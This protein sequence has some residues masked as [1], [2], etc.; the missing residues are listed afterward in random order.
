MLDLM[1]GP[2]LGN[3]MHLLSD[4]I[5]GFIWAAPG[6]KLVVSDYSGIEGA[7]IAW[8]AGEQW[9]LEA[10]HEIIANPELPDMYQRTA[11]QIMGVPVETIGRKHHLRQAVGKLAELGLS[12]AGAVGAFSAMARNYQVDLDEL[13][14]PVME[15]SESIDVEAARE[16]YAAALSRKEKTTQALSGNAWIASELIKR[17]WR[18]SNPAIKQFWWD[19]EEGVRLAVREPGT[20]A[21]VGKV[22]Y[23]VAHGYL[24]CRLPSGRCLAYAN[25]RL[26]PQVYASRLIDGAWAEPEVMEADTAE[27][28]ALA[29][30]CRI[31]RKSFPK[32]TVLGVDGKTRQFVRFGLYGGL[33]AEN[34]VQ[35]AA[36]DIL[37]HGMRLAESAGYAV[38]GHVYDEIITEVDRGFGSPEEFSR[39]ICQL[40]GWAAGLPLTAGGYQSKRYRKD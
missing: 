36:R 40:P 27:R 16:R 29:G 25:P 5:R 32:A 18:A 9:K 24:F 8:L 11:A 23:K 14:E 20:T 1:Y 34:A 21:I 17:A 28:L 13:Y 15:R 19:L 4:S 2:D 26:K 6:K 22:Q 7:V 31:E 30:R 10:M 39:L 33:L 35:A 37:V 3:P 38:I 12:F